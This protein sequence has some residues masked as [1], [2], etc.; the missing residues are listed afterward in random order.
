MIETAGAAL[1]F[2]IL[3]SATFHQQPTIHSSSSFVR[4][5]D[6]RAC[7]FPI[8]PQRAAARGFV[9]GEGEILHRRGQLGSFHIHANQ[10]VTLIL[11][12]DTPF[13]SLLANDERPLVGTGYGKDRVAACGYG[14][15]ADYH[16][17]A[18]DEG[19]G[20]I[21]PGAPDL[22]ER[23]EVT[24]NLAAFHA[25]TGVVGLDGFS[26]TEIAGG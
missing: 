4:D 3:E 17:G 9:V 22:A 1:P 21:G 7:R 23:Y 12:R 10:F 5:V 24:V 2:A 14:L 15:A 6:G 25:R 11:V 26:A 18:G 16:I 13:S 8:Q 19:C 20:F